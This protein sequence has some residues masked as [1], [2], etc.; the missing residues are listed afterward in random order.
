VQLALV[1]HFASVQPI[2]LDLNFPKIGNYIN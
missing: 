1:I 2:K